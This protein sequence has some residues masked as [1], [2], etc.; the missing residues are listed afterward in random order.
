MQFCS[1]IQFENIGYEMETIILAN[2]QLLAIEA[3]TCVR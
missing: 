1:I 3:T 2:I